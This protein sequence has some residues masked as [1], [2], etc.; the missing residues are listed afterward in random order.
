MPME[1]VLLVFGKLLPSLAFEIA[2]FNP[3]PVLKHS[4]CG[5]RGPCASD[6]LCKRREGAG[7]VGQEGSGWL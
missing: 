4:C 7:S 3:L 1:Q 5:W 2:P 6:V